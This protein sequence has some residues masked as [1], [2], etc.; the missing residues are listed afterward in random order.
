M[1]NSCSF[2]NPLAA[3]SCYFLY[4]RWVYSR[5]AA[6]CYNCNPDQVDY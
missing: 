1:D 3:G 5:L 4:I 6:D 2:S